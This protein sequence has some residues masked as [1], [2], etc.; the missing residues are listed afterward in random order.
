MCCDY[1]LHVGVTWWSDEVQRDMKVLVEEK[2][3][4]IIIMAG[5]SLLLLL[6]YY[7]LRNEFIQDVSG[8]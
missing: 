4:I 8:L 5:L 2:G 3:K 7:I 6:R 1:S